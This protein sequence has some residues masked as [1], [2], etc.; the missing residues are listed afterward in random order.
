MSES[1]DKITAAG[2]LETKHRNYVK[3]K[4]LEYVQ[5]I[6][7]YCVQTIHPR[8]VINPKYPLQA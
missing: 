3:S 2:S 7:D 8:K 1:I 6:E 5:H 4:K